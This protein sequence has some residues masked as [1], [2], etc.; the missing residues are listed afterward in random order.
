MN[1]Q[2]QVG[3]FTNMSDQEQEQAG[4]ISSE[5]DGSE[6]PTIAEIEAAMERGDDVEIKPDGVVEITDSKGVK[7]TNIE[8][9]NKIP[10]TPEELVRS[11]PDSVLHEFVG[12]LC[13]E[14]NRAYRGCISE[15][16]GPMWE[17]LTLEEQLTTKRG[18]NFVANNIEITGK[19][20]HDSWLEDKTNQGWRYGPVKSVIHK[21]HPN[22]V[23]YDQLHQTQQAKDGIFLTICRMFFDE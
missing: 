23:P 22:M 16:P 1:D 6:K 10:P 18:V 14:V 5:R 12:K 21:T 9:I 20:M 7:V 2:S 13:H 17:D 19:D 11:M 8:T 3:V 4:G 15:P